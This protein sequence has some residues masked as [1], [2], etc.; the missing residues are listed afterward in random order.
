MNSTDSTM[1]VKELEDE[2]KRLRTTIVS[3]MSE[4]KKLCKLNKTYRVEIVRAKKSK[5]MNS[6]ELTQRNIQ[7]L[8]TNTT[9]QSKMNQM[10]KQLESNETMKN[11]M[12]QIQKQLDD[13]LDVN[14]K[15]PITD[16]KKI[17]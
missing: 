6:I 16:D 9:M 13:I 1:N 14:L 12:N 2:N 15:C 4:K 7:L 17:G 11:K 3:L 5:L 8:T 10:Q